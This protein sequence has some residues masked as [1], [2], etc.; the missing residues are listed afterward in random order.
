MGG[1]GGRGHLGGA[2]HPPISEVD[3]PRLPSWQR[4][5]ATQDN[6]QLTRA[7]KGQR[8]QQKKITHFHF[9]SAAAYIPTRRFRSHCR[10]RCRFFCRSSTGRATPKPAAVP[11]RPGAT[12]AP[13][14]RSPPRRPPAPA[15]PPPRP[16]VP[17]PR[18][19]PKY[20]HHSSPGVDSLGCR[21]GS[22]TLAS[23]A[24]PSPAA[25]R[26]RP[27]ASS[28]AFGALRVH[29]VSPNH[30]LDTTTKRKKERGV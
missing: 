4:Y 26:S 15:R 5:D 1:D 14:R 18:P 27:V 22:R 25:R 11:T 19:P 10:C 29:P 17:P 23:L 16:P 28:A 2:E 24:A 7:P 6:I 13:P 21:T 8:L 3:S 12:G 30:C 20:R 9:Y